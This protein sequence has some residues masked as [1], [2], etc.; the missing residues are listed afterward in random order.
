MRLTSNPFFPYIAQRIEE[1]LPVNSL[2]G[3]P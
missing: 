2:K 1:R 3:P